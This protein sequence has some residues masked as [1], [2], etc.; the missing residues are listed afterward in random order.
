[1]RELVDTAFARAGL[2]ER[3]DVQTERALP[4]ASAVAPDAHAMAVE[5]PWHLARPLDGDPFMPQPPAMEPLRKA[6]SSSD[7]K[8]DAM[9]V[10]AASSNSIATSSSRGSSASNKPVGA[11][12]GDEPP[13]LESDE[14]HTQSSLAS[15]RDG[16]S[17]SKMSVDSD[18]KAYMQAQKRSAADSDEDDLL[19]DEQRT[20]AAKRARLGAHPAA[21]AA[22]APMRSPPPSRSQSQ[23]QSHA[24]DEDDDELVVL[25]VKIRRPPPAALPSAVVPRLLQNLVKMEAAAEVHAAALTGKL[26]MLPLG[27]LPQVPNMQQLKPEQLAQLNEIAWLQLRQQQIQQQQQGLPQSV[28]HLQQPLQNQQYQQAAM[29]SPA[30]LQSAQNVLQGLTSLVSSSLQDPDTSAPN[31]PQRRVLPKLPTPPQMAVQL[32]PHQQ[33]GL[34][35]LYTREQGQGSSAAI[36]ADEMSLGKVITAFGTR[37]LLRRTVRSL[38]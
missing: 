6:Q 1:V 33:E 20:T 37:K 24:H 35:F 23:P 26:P 31:A 36:L 27:M 7:S 11:A 29:S 12:D 8:D 30:M 21:I 3:S 25:D 5:Q 9:D 19:I 34:H 28:H 32:M 2:D 14:A 15:E 22:S 17:L 4:G 38:S 18:F 10:E 16:E 13:A